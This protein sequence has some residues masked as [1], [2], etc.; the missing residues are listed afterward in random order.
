LYQRKNKASLFDVKLKKNKEGNEVVFSS[1][2]P[3]IKKSLK[4]RAGKTL[5]DQM[6]PFLDQSYK[7]WRKFRSRMLRDTRPLVPEKTQKKSI[8]IPT[9]TRSV[10]DY[11]KE[12][13][14]IK[15]NLD[16]GP[17]PLISQNDSLVKSSKIHEFEPTNNV[18][19]IDNL[20]N[21]ANAS[22]K[23]FDMGDVKMILQE[24]LDQRL[25]LTDEDEHT[26]YVVVGN[27]SD[28][29]QSDRICR[30]SAEN[31]GNNNIVVSMD[32]EEIS[33][34]KH[35]QKF[36]NKIMP[37]SGTSEGLDEFFKEEL[38][39]FVGIYMDI[40]GA[41]MNVEKMAEYIKEHIFQPKS[42][43]LVENSRTNSSSN[44]QEVVF[45]AL[46]H[47]DPQLDQII[48]QLRIYKIN[49]L[50]NQVQISHR[51]REI[52]LQVPRNMGDAQKTQLE[53]EISDVLNDA[54]INN[55]V[56]FNQ[57][58]E[59][60]INSLKTNHQCSDVN[61]QKHS[62]HTVV[63]EVNDESGCPFAGM[64]I[65]VTGF[66]YD[67][68]Q[69]MHLL[70]DNQYFQAEHLIA[71][72]L[73]GDFTNNINDVFSGMASNIENVQKNQGQPIVGDLT[74]DD[75]TR[76]IEQVL[77]NEVERLNLNENE[78]VYKRKTEHGKEVTVIRILVV[79]GDGDGDNTALYRVFLFDPSGHKKGLHH[80]KSQHEYMMYASN[81]QD[82]LKI[83]AGD[84]AKWKKKLEHRKLNRI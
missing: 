28:P 74:I 13:R 10:S 18:H 76:A 23:L 46:D 12:A 65:V 39:E 26:W 62:G 30:I 75:L 6:I 5:N 25:T 49:H 70:L 17:S 67:Y 35:S 32:N 80:T 73:E 68:L 33:S 7:T 29:N 83:F 38:A 66:D 82:E 77:G 9:K 31:D 72:T 15:K 21:I 4:L 55:T 61:E 51:E 54:V 42:I 20:D 57:S 69:Y 27:A 14:E 50:Y 53:A 8:E 47:I 81:G 40:L 59:I 3:Y 58:I 2:N 43:Q 37:V 11:S 1:G 56:G 22:R 34:L 19:F 48:T 52:D 60:M 63:L 71:F 45:I 64:S 84:L 79:P 41:Q 78:I 24:S 36:V 44:P 16:F